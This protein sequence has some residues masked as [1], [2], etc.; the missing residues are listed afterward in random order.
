MSDAA[1]RL[2]RLERLE[3]RLLLAED[4]IDALNKT[5]Y[6][7]QGVIERLQEQMRQLARQVQS[8]QAAAQGRPEDE[9]PPHW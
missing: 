6:R 5:V 2:E 3:A 9:I 8:A 1:E 7:Q 4:Q